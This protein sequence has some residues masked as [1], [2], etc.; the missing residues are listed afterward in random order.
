MNV[1]L[2]LRQI[3]CDIFKVYFISMNQIH[4]DRQARTEGKMLGLFVAPAPG[5]LIF[6]FSQNKL[7]S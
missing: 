6:F 5:S 7:H 3:P 1:W 2:I 4:M